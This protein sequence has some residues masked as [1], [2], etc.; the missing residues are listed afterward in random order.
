MLK[1]FNTRISKS[2]RHGNVKEVKPVV[3]ADVQDNPGAGCS[4]DTVGV[5][6]SL[7]SYNAHAVLA[8]L[9][10]PEV[11]KMAHS[12]GIGNVLESKLGNSIRRF[13]FVS[14]EFIYVYKGGSLEGH[15]PFLGKF[16]V[17]NISQGKF[18][19]EGKMM[20]GTR[21]N[22]GATALLRVLKGDGY[23]RVIVSSS[24]F[25]CLD[26]AVFSHIGINLSQE[27]IVVVKS[28]VHFR[29]AFTP[30]AS[31]V[32]MAASKGE[33]PCDLHQVPF[34]GLRKDVRLLRNK[35]TD[36]SRTSGAS[37]VSLTTTTKVSAKL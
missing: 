35:E 18:L 24:R 19:C 26:T 7:V 11:A 8:L 37:P 30:I 36:S 1:L 21:T 20:K 28:S 17:E 14:T 10:D 32:I 13:A 23:V 27:K 29:A 33:N 22:L 31:C 9:Y 2:I 16:E 15:S 12:V 34:K 4:S 3:I 25:Q 5:L 6:Q